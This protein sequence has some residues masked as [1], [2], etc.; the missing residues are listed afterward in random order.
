[1][2]FL[3]ISTGEYP[4]THTQI[5]AKY[6]EKTFPAYFTEIEGFEFVAST[7]QP[8]YI[9]GEEIIIEDAPILVDNKYV[10]AWKVV[11]LT[12]AEKQHAQSLTNQLLIQQ[13]I[14]QTQY[15]LDSFAKTRGYDDIKSASTYAGC[16][17]QKYNT[18][19]TYARDIRAQVWDT[20]YTLLDKINKGEEPFPKNI[21]EVI[22][23]LPT[24]TWPE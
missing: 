19:G 1:M 5:R 15:I 21:G 4:I 24:L 23:R 8:S 11:E 17:I 12:D 18:E 13:I 16:S 10:Q 14:Q 7:P 2:S 6:P 20:L 9:K 3:D 22:N